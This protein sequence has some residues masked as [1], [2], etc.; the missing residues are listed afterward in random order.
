[1]GAVGLEDTP[2]PD[3]FLLGAPKAGTTSMYHW[4]SQHPGVFM[5]PF[6]EPR[7]FCHDLTFYYRFNHEADYLGLFGAAEGYETVGEASTWY[8]RSERAAGEIADF[9]ARTGEDPRLIAI[10]RNPVEMAYSWHSELVWM[11]NEPHEDFR[12]AYE[13]QDRRREGYELPD[14]VNPYEGLFYSEIADYP[15]QLQ[16]YLD[17]FGEDAL[18]VIVFDDLV[19]DNERTWHELCD[20][21]DL[22]PVDVTYQ[23]SNPNE[24][25]RSHW[26]RELT[27]DLPSP[28]QAVTS[29]LPT[30]LRL[31][32][33]EAVQSINTV[34]AERDPLPEDLRARLVEDYADTV[35]ELG[36]MLDRDLSHWLEAEAA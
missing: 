25:V 17:T 3:T 19:E 7:Y 18:H 34:E 26:F 15:P 2:T 5:S 22:D 30:G 20:F 33:R 23:R 8:L 31:R 4:L 10:L 12:N 27:R 13:A 21:L 6:K 1:M 36:E 24:E 14:R 16:R 29:R 11:G 35:H 28:A 32:L 9:A